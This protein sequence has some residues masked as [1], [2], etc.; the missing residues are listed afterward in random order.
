MQ[1]QCFR[2]FVK[3]VRLV[4]VDNKAFLPEH[5]SRVWAAC[6]QSRRS[7]GPPWS[8]CWPGGRGWSASPGM[9]PPTS[10]SSFSNTELL[11]L[12]LYQLGTGGYRDWSEL[13]RVEVNISHHAKQGTVKCKFPPFTL[14]TGVARQ[15]SYWFTL[16]VLTLDSSALTSAIPTL[17]DSLPTRGFH[18]KDS[19]MKF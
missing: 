14:V 19:L 5:R 2:L 9:L 10:L 18:V 6:C 15:L 11:P 3:L 1:H 12:I 8:K 7:P 16:S 4:H 17:W 13:R